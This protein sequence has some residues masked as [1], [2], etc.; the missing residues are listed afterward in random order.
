M[1]VDANIFRSFATAELLRDSTCD[2]TRPEADAKN[3]VAALLSWTWPEAV[4]ESCEWSSS[5]TPQSNNTCLIGL[6][7]TFNMSSNDRL[8]SSMAAPRAS[9]WSAGN[10]LP[11]LAISL[12]D[13]AT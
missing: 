12:R 1:F 7:W 4:V 9:T 11:H 8:P 3:A 2:W 5:N 6:S 10:V 13:A